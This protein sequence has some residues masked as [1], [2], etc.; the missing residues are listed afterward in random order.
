MDEEFC[1]KSGSIQS[2]AT[3]QL[4]AS[5]EAFRQLSESHNV[6]DHHQR[7]DHAAIA[8]VIEVRFLTAGFR[9]GNGK[10]S[11]TRLFGLIAI[12]SVLKPTGSL[13]GD[14]ALAGAAEGMPKNRDVLHTKLDWVNIRSRSKATP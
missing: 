14:L 13:R 5:A 8:S 7:Q 12:G 9:D 4:L 1:F 6:W 3:G 10:H 11:R 2:S